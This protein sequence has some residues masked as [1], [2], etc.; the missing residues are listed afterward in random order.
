M[1]DAQTLVAANSYFETTF[2]YIQ[3]SG[4]ISFLD[5]TEAVPESVLAMERVAARDNLQ[6][7]TALGE[8]SRR[9]PQWQAVERQIKVTICTTEQV[10]CHMFLFTHSTSRLM[11]FT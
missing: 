4:L 10:M 7:A 11:I 2:C 8:G 9:P 3:P 6:M 1:R 5:S